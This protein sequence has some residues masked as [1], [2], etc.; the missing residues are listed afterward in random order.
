MLSVVIETKNDEEALARTLA[1]LVG[2]AVEGIVREVIVC[3]IG[4][5]DQTQ[6]VADHAGCHYVGQGGVA[7]GIRQ[8]RCEWILLLEPGARLVDGWTDEVLAHTGRQTIAARFSQAK[9][10]RAPFLS[11]LFGRRRPLTEG[12]VISKHQ[13]ASLA[14][15]ASG[16][17]ALARGV[18]TKRLDAEIWVAPLKR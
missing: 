3:D 2:G 16:A 7:A 17:E 12:L 14:G 13:A 15:K 4:S 6:R 8:A 11:R 10:S 1:S 9:A 5:T 18:A